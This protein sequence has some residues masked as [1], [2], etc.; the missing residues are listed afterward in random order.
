M[1][2][3]PG[4]QKAEVGRFVFQ[5]LPGQNVRLYLK[6][7]LKAKQLGC[8]SSDSGLASKSKALSSIPSTGK[9]NK[10]EY[11]VYIKFQSGKQ[12]YSSPYG[13]FI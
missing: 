10:I 2:E 13:G 7:K 4:T 12:A 1:P 5:C 3:I 11:K 9:L 8:G 6:N